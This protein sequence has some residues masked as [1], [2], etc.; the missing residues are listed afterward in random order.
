MT[1]KSTTIPSR[2]SSSA[3]RCRLA[4]TAFALHPLVDSVSIAERL[5]AGY[6]ER[7]PEVAA[8]LTR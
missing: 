5:V 7:I 3:F 1:A 4:V 6:V 2:W 8:V